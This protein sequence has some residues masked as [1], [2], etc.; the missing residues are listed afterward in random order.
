MHSISWSFVSTAVSSKLV[1]G[2]ANQS[3]YAAELLKEH[4]THADMC[5][6]PAAAPEAVRPR[7][8][9][10]PHVAINATVLEARMPQATHLP[11]KRRIDSNIE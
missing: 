8:Q 1:R 9:L 2:A 3:I 7:H 6:P 10:E 11:L 5:S 4:V